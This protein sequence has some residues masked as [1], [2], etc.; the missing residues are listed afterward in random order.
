MYV[1]LWVKTQEAASTHVSC[2][3]ASYVSSVFWNVFGSVSQFLELVGT[4]VV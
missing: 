2:L 4:L 1:G 3:L